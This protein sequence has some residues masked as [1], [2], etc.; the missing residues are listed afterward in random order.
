MPPKRWVAS[1]NPHDDMKEK[2]EDSSINLFIDTNV[3]LGFYRF[4]NDDLGTL[5]R[6]ED[7][8]VKTRKIKLY[9]TQQQVDE[10]YRNRDGVIKQ[11]VDSFKYSQPVLPKVFSGH[12]DYPEIVRESRE[13]ATKINKVKQDTL[14]D[15]LKEN[16]RADA[17]VKNIFKSPIATTEDI[18]HRARMRVDVGNPPGKNGSLGD[19]INWEIL[20]DFVDSKDDFLTDVHIISGDGDFSSALDEN[21]I[22]SFLGSEWSSRKFGTAY[23]YRSLNSFFEKHFPDIELVDEAIKDGIVEQIG[24]ASSFDNARALIARLHKMGNLSEDQVKVLFKSATSND[25]VYKAH[26]YSPTI[27]GDRLWELIKPYWSK[28]SDEAQEVWASHFPDEKMR[29]IEEETS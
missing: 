15:A 10:F 21:K 11:N 29:A 1:R 20:L 23:L 3:F 16:L 24:T 6:L 12:S 28:L 5:G 18:F 9:V 17:V 7:L 19:A 27:V 13:L 2:K 4:T 26:T 8:I 25:Q 22:G 14:D